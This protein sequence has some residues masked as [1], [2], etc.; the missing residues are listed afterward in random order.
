MRFDVRLLIGLMFL[1][2]GVIVTVTGIA[3][4]RAAATTASQGV[5]IDL[6][7]GLVMTG[8]GGVMAGLALFSGRKNRP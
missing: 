2:L 3:G 7:W 6:V 5:N 8:F 4:G 1:I